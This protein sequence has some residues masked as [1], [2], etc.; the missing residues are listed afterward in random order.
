MPARSTPDAVRD[1]LADLDIS[2]TTA[3]D[4]TECAHSDE[5]SNLLHKNGVETKNLDPELNFVP[6]VLFNNVNRFFSFSTLILLFDNLFRFS[7]R[8]PGRPD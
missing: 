6:W 7:I 5:G 2:T 8:T 4:V 1:C 3:E